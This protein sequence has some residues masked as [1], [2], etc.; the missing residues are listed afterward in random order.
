MNTYDM[1]IMMFYAL[2]SRYDE[3]S[4]E[5]FANFLSS[6]NPFLF[7]DEGSAV[8][9]VYSEFKEAYQKYGKN[10]SDEYS[11]VSLFIDTECDLVI[12]KAFS[13][14]SREEWDEALE[15]YKANLKK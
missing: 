7:A 1:F 15:I 8:P 10:A 4:P 2:D 5:E 12:K 3:D 11:F 9:Y 6:A 13:E 14:I